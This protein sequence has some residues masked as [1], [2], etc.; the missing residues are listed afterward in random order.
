VVDLVRTSYQQYFDSYQNG[1]GVHLDG[2]G[3]LSNH[4][5]VSHR[6]YQRETSQR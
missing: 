1:G 4:P 6:I 2:V 3:G 5:A